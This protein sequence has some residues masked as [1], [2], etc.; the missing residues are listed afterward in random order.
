MGFLKD[1]TTYLQR[2]DRSPRTV[3]AYRREVAAFF[4]WLRKQTG[5]D[6][7]A[8]QVTTFD[9]KR[10]RQALEDAGRKPATI[11]HH[12][13]ALRVFFD[14]AVKEE[15][16]ASN[17][18]AAVEGI[19]QKRRAP[20]ALSEQEVYLLQRQAAQRRQLAE[21]KAG[22]DADGEPVVTPSVILA[23][24]DEA[25]LALLLN[26]GLRVGEAAGLRMRDLVLNAR[27][28]KVCVTKGKGRKY[29]EVPLNPEARA[30]LRAYLEVRAKPGS[31]GETLFL[32]QRGALSVRGIQMRLQEIGEEAEVAVT[33]HKFR[34]TF[35]TRLLREHDV[36]L[37][38]TADLLG[39]QSVNTTAIYTQPTEADLE[40]AVDKLVGE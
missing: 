11:N 29:R 18:A 33:A 21:A 38:T 28:G 15:H 32:G 27:S 35:A 22:R 12:L 2:Q 39:H 14:W 1:F 36:D 6:V 30:A 19:E 25:I 5:R 17:P 26:T 34:H 13:A 8:A 4:A 24:R 40:A 7:Q 10:Y 3:A 31:D 20:K 37:V 16:V 9:V 23:R